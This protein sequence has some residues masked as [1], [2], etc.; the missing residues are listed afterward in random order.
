[1]AERPNQ[2][3]EERC[4]SSW[5][6]NFRIDSGNPQM[7]IAGEHVYTIYGV[8]NTKDQSSIGL[9]QSGLFSISCDRDIQITAGKKNDTEGVDIA[10]TSFDGDIT[11]TCLRNGSVRLKGRNIVL[12][13]LEDIDIIAGRNISITA[14]STLKLK[15]MKVELDESSVAGNIVEAVLGS[16]GSQIFGS[17]PTAAAIGLDI[18]GGVFGGPIAGAAFETAAGFVGDAASIAGAPGEIATENLEVGQFNTET[19]QLAAQEQNLIEGQQAQ[20]LLD[21]GTVTD[22]DGTTTSFELF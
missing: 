19:Q 4:Y 18:I 7:G 22:A 17:L 13:A 1:M 16:F 3:W 12:D 2:N 6:P 15:G 5:G 11:L 10:L 14:G 20:T 21:G 8:T 9:D